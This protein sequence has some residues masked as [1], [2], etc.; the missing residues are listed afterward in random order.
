MKVS[1]EIK[2]QLKTLEEKNIVADNNE[3]FAIYN[4][5]SSMNNVANIFDSMNDNLIEKGASP[6]KL[7][8]LIYSE[9]NILVDN[10]TWKER[11]ADFKKLY[12][13]WKINNKTLFN[14]EKNKNIAYLVSFISKY[15]KMGL[16][17]LLDMFF[18]QTNITED[19]GNTTIKGSLEKDLD[20]LFNELKT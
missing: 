8:Y 1:E 10:G 20:Y 14:T 5:L 13:S 18:S 11:L 6:M 19:N 16:L 17:L 2:M 3:K 12:K 4:L 15:N 7:E 9:D